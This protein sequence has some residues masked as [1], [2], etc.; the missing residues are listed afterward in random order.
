MKYDI[1]LKSWSYKLWAYVQ[2]EI[3]EK[4]FGRTTLHKWWATKQ[5]EIDKW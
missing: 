2:E 4:S 1:Y 5:Q 3:F